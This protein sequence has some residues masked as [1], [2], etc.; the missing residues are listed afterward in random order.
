MGT[1]LNTAVAMRGYVMAD[2]ATWLNFG[3]KSNMAILLEGDP[4]LFNQYAFLPVSQERHPHVKR[5][6]VQR[7]EDWLISERGQKSIGDFRLGNV[8][9]FFPNAK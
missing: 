3:N 6:A 2:R 9:L 5:E 1:T 7:L 8:Q 4:S